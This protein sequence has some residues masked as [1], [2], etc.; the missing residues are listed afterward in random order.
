MDQLISYFSDMPTTHRTLALVGGLAF[1]YL[2]EYLA[3]FFTK[4]YNWFTHTG[5]NLFFTLTTIIVNFAMAFLLLKTSDWVV[6]SKIGFMQ[7]VDLPIVISAVIAL[8]IMDFVGAWLIHYIEHHVKW[9]W[10]FHLIHHTDQNVDTFSANRHHPGESI[11]RF[12]FTI[13]AVLVAGAPIWMVFLYQS[14]SLIMS[15][16]NHSNIAFPL[17]LDKILSLVICTPHMHRV[18]HHYRM[19]YS[20]MNYGNIFSFWDRLA[21]TY[22]RV[23]N[24]K[25]TYGVDTHMDAHYAENIWTL[26]K[27]PFQPYRKHLKY[28]SEEKL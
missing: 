8:M 16:F 19:P 25:I 9:M 24:S 20:D 28:D 17:G 7:W 27:I 26:L 3:P 12:T 5:T 6:E 2:F 23:D 1:F 18:H 21:R 22:V 4:K 15:Q 10:K 11:F 14:A 13:L